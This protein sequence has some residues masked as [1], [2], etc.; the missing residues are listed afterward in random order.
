[1]TAISAQQG[2]EHDNMNV[3]VLGGRTVSV[4]LARRG[5]ASAVKRAFRNTADS[6]W[7]VN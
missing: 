1:M 4:E 2:V 3:L 5:P 6:S 7:A